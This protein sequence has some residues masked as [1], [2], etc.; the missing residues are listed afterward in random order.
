MQRTLRGFLMRCAV[1]G[2]PGCSSST[3][4]QCRRVQRRCATV[5]CVRWPAAP[6]ARRRARCRA[7]SV[8]P[9]TL[10]VASSTQSNRAGRSSARP[11]LRSCRWPRERAPS[12]PAASSVSR[13]PGSARTIFSRP[14]SS[15]PAQ[16]TASSCSALGPP[17][18]CSRGRRLRRTE[19]AKSSG[20]CGTAATLARRTFSGTVRMSTPSMVIRPASSSANLRMARRQELL[21]QPDAPMRPTDSPART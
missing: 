5:S 20:S 3:S 14:S 7:A 4:S 2:G 15:S 1:V 11:R 16:Q 6:A 21:P 19:P 13:Q 12:S 17:A 8:A 9:S 18:P 10:A